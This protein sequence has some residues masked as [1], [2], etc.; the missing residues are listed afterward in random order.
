[1]FIAEL[2]HPEFKRF[3]L[4]SLR[5]GIMAAAAERIIVL[6]DHT[7]V[8]VETMCETVALKRITTLITDSGV[9]PERLAALREAGLEVLVAEV[10]ADGGAGVPADDP[11]AG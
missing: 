3:D 6:A 8:G 10:G 4:S 11:A 9:G 2:G 5:T 7:K 1:M